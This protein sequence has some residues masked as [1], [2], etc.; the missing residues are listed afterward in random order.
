M[1]LKFATGHVSVRVELAEMQ[2]LVTDGNLSE[3][4]ELAGGAMTVVVSLVD[5]DIANML[6]DPNTATIGF[7]YPRPAVEAE[8]AKPSRN[9]IGGYFEQGVFS[10]A[11]DMHDIR[12]QAA[13][14]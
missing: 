2:Q 12:Q 1:K 3:T 7:V 9:G 11:I 6:F 13:D 10:L 5:E 14:K 8:L 4:I